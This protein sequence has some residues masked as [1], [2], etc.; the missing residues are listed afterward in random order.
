MS[1]NPISSV[2]RTDW[3]A[4]LSVASLFISFD[5]SIEK[6]CS[7][8]MAFWKGN[9]VNGKKSVKE[10]K[11]SEWGGGKRKFRLGRSEKKSSSSSTCVSVPSFLLRLFLFNS[12]SSANMH[13]LLTEHQTFS[14]HLSKNDQME[15]VVV[16]VFCFVFFLATTFKVR[17]WLAPTSQ[18]D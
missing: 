13:W 1:A 7:I 3:T 15:I 9:V 10:S 14:S 5:L 4:N 12:K 16:F 18:T 8:W 2:T 6:T 11:E 17:K